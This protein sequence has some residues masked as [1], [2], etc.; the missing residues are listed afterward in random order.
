MLE[1][2]NTTTSLDSEDPAMEQNWSIALMPR[3][4]GK[5]R[6]VLSFG[7][8]SC[9]SLAGSCDFQSIGTLL[10]AFRNM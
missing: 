3:T 2:M 9:S 5:P 7:Y 4:L 6:H 1:N 8:A 10:R